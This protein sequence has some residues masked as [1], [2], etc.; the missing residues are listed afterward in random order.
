V[1]RLLLEKTDRLAHRGLD[2]QGLDVL[3]VLLEQRD[4]EV[5]AQH[6]VS[7]N[8]IVG[9]LD[10]TNS[11]TQAKN[12]LQLEL[13]GGANFSELVS[14]VLSVRYRCGELA[15]LGETGTKKTRNLLDESLRGQEGIVL[16]GELLDKLLVLVQLL[17]IVDGHVLQVNLLS[18]IDIGSIC[19]NADGHARAGNIGQLDGARETLISL[20]IVVLETNLEFDS[21]D[22]VTSLLAVGIGEELLDRAPHA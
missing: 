17:Q 8:L 1:T 16:L 7:K 14:E 3:P 18:T 4:E 9:H 11:D 21:L 13:D 2:V 10:V 20:G 5:D 22:E 15:S 6:D 19:E 12:L